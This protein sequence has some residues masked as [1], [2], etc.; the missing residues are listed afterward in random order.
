MAAEKDREREEA[1]A[2]GKQEELPLMHGVPI[3]VKDM[4]A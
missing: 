3:S 1:I 2:N 4:L